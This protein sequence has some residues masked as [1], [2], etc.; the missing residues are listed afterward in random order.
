MLN[1]SL[2]LDMQEPYEDEL[3]VGITFRLIYLLTVPSVKKASG[4]QEEEWD[5]SPLEQQLKL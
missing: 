1:P 3:I 2:L 4:V 5:V